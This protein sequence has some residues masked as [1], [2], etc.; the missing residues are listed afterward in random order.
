MRKQISFLCFLWSRVAQCRLEDLHQVPV[1]A[2]TTARKQCTWALDWS[3][4]GGDFLVKPSA[5]SVS[6]LHSFS[7]KIV[8]RTTERLD[9][10][11]DLLNRLCPSGRYHHKRKYL[12]LKIK[13]L[14]K[15]RPCL[16]FFRDFLTPFVVFRPLVGLS[17]SLWAA[18][19]TTGKSTIAR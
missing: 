7:I 14:G 2:E 13:F 16:L 18:C 12:V 15:S 17:S 6:Q 1:D 11:S 4:T 10:G 9:R 3:C 8:A 19:L 5:R